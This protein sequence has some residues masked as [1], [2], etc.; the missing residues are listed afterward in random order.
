ME[1][2]IFRGYVRHRRFH[3]KSYIFTYRTDMYFLDVQRIEQTCKSLPYLSYNRFN[4][5][6]FND[7]NYLPKYSG[8]LFQR[9]QKV[10]EQH[11]YEFNVSNAYILTNL[12]YLGFCYNPVSFYYCYSEDNSLV[13]ILAEVNNTPWNERYTYVLPCNTSK[14]KF[15]FDTDKVFHISPFM[16]MNMRYKWY[17]N[18]PSSIINF[19]I[20]TFLEEKTIFDATLSL[21]NIPLT[22]TNIF[23]SILLRPLI[24]Q[25]VKFSIYWQALKM[26]LRRFPIFEHPGNINAS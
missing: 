3:P 17:T 1:N 7:N 11:G 10:I 12:T 23:T 5:L 15:E 4:L 8:S 9:I 19:H 16:P 6:S 24:S 26:W 21:K 20:Q 13:Y 2:A 22:T 14:D 18:A 25:K